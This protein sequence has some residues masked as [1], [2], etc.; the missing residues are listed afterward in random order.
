[1]GVISQADSLYHCRL[2]GFLRRQEMAGRFGTDKRF[3]L[4]ALLGLL[5]LWQ[6]AVGQDA[7]T[8]LLQLQR[9]RASLDISS[10]AK[11]ALGMEGLT[12]GNPGDVWNYPNSLSCLVVY[13]TGRYVLEKREEHT[14]GKPKV[15]S[16]EGTLT[17][18]DLQQLKA[19][20]DDETLKAIK[21]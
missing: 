2:I 16:A 1:M 19:I 9:S 7:S 20:L 4:P 6:G 21:R 18:D 14:V 11:H 12:Y 17:A 13:G 3:R 5:A 15:K 8:T 10:N